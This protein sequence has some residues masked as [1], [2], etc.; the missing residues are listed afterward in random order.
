MQSEVVG[1]G[2]ELVERDQADAVF[3][4]HGRGDKRI[5]ADD[6]EAE[7]ARASGHFKP[8]AAEAENAEGLAAQLRALQALLLPLAG[9]HGVVGGGQLAGQREHEADGELGDGDGVGAGRVHDDDAAAGGGFGIDVVDT[10]AGA[11]DDAQLRRVLH[12]RV[13]DLHG[14]ADHEC[15]GI[16]ERGGQTIGNWSCVRTSHPGSA[17]NT[18]SV[19]GE[20]FSA[21]TIFIL[22][23]L[24]AV[25]DGLKFVEAD[26]VLFA[27]QVEHAHNGGV[28]LALAALVF[29]DGVGMHAQLLGHLVWI[30]IEL[31]ARDEQFFAKREFRH[32]DYPFAASAYTFCAAATACP[33]STLSPS[34]SFAMCSI[35]PSRATVSR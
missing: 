28:R 29:G 26:A 20:T 27:E 18:A 10:H 35:A 3:A 31:L 14:A 9:V 1:A 12:Q 32:S 23:P 5:A 6:F 4:R 30:E 15:I 33:Y 19:A 2:D 22:S 13:V 25:A 8:D 7:T 17:A 16:G 24:S 21:R 34:V 11:A